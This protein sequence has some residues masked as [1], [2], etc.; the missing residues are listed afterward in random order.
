MSEQNP[1]SG[2]PT[3][4][5]PVEPV[6][7]VQAE[8]TAQFDAPAEVDGPTASD[9]DA[10]PPA[11]TTDTTATGETPEP[12]RSKSRA[13]W[14][15]GVAVVL[16]LALVGGG[17][18]AVLA[19]KGDPK[20]SITI[21]STAGG[22]KRDTAKETSLKQELDA[23]DKQFEDQ[24]EGTSVKHALYNQTSKSR[25]PEGQLLF[26]G[27]KFKTKSEKNPGKFIKQLDKIASSN[28]LKVTKISVGDGDGRAVCVGTPS[29]AAQRS[30]SCLW[31]TN[32]SAG[33]LFPNTLGYSPDQLSKILLDVRDDVEKSD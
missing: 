27:F 1:P 21:T 28:Q 23:A 31:V 25:G 15:V 33:G 29:N 12:E 3:P 14:I 2:Q 24:F 30:A 17:I 13:P 19:L 26:V 7:P 6:E 8:Q 9:G 10:A 32:D 18:F 5:E 11:Y 16:V 22:M 4:G 20:H